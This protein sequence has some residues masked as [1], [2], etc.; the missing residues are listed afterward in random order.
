MSNLKK[1]ACDSKGEVLELATLSTIDNIGFKLQYT[2]K[3]P[4]STTWKAKFTKFGPI[5]AGVDSLYI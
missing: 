4:I 3:L 2:I 1:A 5:N